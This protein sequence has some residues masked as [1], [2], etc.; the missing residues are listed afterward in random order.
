MNSHQF[1]HR[2]LLLRR[3]SPVRKD[4]PAPAAQYEGKPHGF[5]CRIAG[6]EKVSGGDLCSAARKSYFIR[7]RLT[8]ARNSYIVANIVSIQRGVSEIYE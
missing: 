8:Q 7:L 5:Y 6:V 2:Q 4:T 3:S 1:I